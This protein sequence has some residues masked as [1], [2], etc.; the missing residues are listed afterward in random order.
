MGIPSRPGVMIYFEVE[1]PLKRLSYEEKG[2]L[3]EA[4]LEYAHYGTLPNFDGNIGVAWDFICDKVDRDIQRY[5]NAVA[6]KAYGGY[7]SSCKRNG[8][9]PLPFSAWSE[10]EGFF[11]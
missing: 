2:M 4:I 8:V 10:R 1:R 11:T 3:F 7:K 9:E 6:Q 5:E